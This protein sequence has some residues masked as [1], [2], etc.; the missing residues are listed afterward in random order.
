MGNKGNNLKDNKIKLNL[1]RGRMEEN[2]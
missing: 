1:G 2:D